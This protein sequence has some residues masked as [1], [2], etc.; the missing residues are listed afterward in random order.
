MGTITEAHLSSYR[1]D[2]NA[3]GRRLWLEIYIKHDDSEPGRGQRIDFVDMNGNAKVT[4][5]V[6]RYT[7]DGNPE[8][9]DEAFV[10]SYG[11]T[12]EGYIRDTLASVEK[13]AHYFSEQAP[14]QNAYTRNT[15]STC[16]SDDRSYTFSK[17]KTTDAHTFISS[18]DVYDQTLPYVAD[19]DPGFQI[20]AHIEQECPNSAYTLSVYGLRLRME[21]E[22]RCVGTSHHGYRFTVH[23][24][25][26]DMAL[27]AGAV[28]YFRAARETLDPNDTNT[29]HFGRHC[30]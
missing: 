20:S 5:G 15:R 27:I 14:I 19:L 26:P 18:I 8:P 25:S 30:P 2:H 9:V 7:I 29:G 16:P 23:P 4:L 24:D 11:E 3:S 10:G 28:K 22:D 13:T 21:S 17:T 6:D 1:D 12:I